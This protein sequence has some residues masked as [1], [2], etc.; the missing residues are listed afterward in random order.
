MP[1][2]KEEVLEGNDDIFV[3]EDLLRRVVS[4]IVREELQGKLGERITRNLRRMVRREIE[5]TLSLKD[6]D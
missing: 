3:D 1:S 5:Q 4:D 6:F 2:A